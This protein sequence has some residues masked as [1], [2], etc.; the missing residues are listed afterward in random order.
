MPRDSVCRATDSMTSDKFQQ[1]VFTEGNM[2]LLEAIL[3]REKR[4]ANT[5]TWSACSARPGM[6]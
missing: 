5:D 4:E 3:K 2:A 1:L 6:S